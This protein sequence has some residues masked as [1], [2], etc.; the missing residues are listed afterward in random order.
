LGFDLQLLSGGESRMLG[1]D[2]QMVLNTGF[3][4]LNVLAFCFILYI[5]LYK[6]VRRFLAAR[7]EGIEKQLAETALNLRHAEESKAAYDAKLQKIEEE[8]EGILS[9]ATKK[10]REKADQILREAREEADLL[11]KRAM[12]DISREQ[13]RVKDEIRLQMLEIS[14]LMAGRFVTAHMDEGTRNKMFEEAVADLGDAKW[15][16]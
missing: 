16:T 2:L 14:A 6:P 1:F 9:L 10:A 11:R 3:Y 5:L 8:R 7:A 13:D 15:R 4:V 12:T